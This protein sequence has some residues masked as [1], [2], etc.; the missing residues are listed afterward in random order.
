MAAFIPA[1]S[2]PLVNTAIRFIS[3]LSLKD[4]QP[5][6]VR[7]RLNDCALQLTGQSNQ[8]PSSLGSRLVG[9]LF[10]YE[11]SPSHC[12]NIPIARGRIHI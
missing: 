10:R 3:I 8:T 9:K 11:I 12:G 6:F 2:P 1:A 7:M 5:I 4:Y